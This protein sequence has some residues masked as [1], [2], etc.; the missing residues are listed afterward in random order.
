MA[1]PW[2]TTAMRLDRVTCGEHRH[3]ALH[4]RLRN[5]VVT[6]AA[7]D[8]VPAAGRLH[9][10]N[11]GSPIAARRRNSPLPQSPSR[12]SSRS[13]CVSSGQPALVG[14]RLRG[15]HAPARG[16]SCRRRGALR[17]E[18]AARRGGLLARR[19]SCSGGS[20]DS[21]VPGTTSADRPWRMSSTSHMSTEARAI[22]EGCGTACVLSSSI[23]GFVT[24]ATVPARRGRRGL[25]PKCAKLSTAVRAGER[26]PSDHSNQT[27]RR[28]RARLPRA[29][30]DDV[31]TRPRR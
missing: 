13:T 22:N 29:G 15:L 23:V 16:A 24:A 14:Q 8:A 30:R 10:T 7:G 9:A 1:P 2:A 18:R 4:T 25:W 28:C 31:D 21:G 5:D 11:S 19:C 27:S 26:P 17:G 6:L 20:A 12:I 3:T